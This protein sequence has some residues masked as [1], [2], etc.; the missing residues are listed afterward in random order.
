MAQLGLVV[1][2][3]S[4]ITTAGKAMFNCGVHRYKDNIIEFDRTERF[5]ETP[6]EAVVGAALWLIENRKVGT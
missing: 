4:W 3:T 1:L 2:V 5:R 6:G